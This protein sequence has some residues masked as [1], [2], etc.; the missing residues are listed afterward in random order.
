MGLREQLGAAL[1][2]EF[3]HHE[4]RGRVCAKCGADERRL[5]THVAVFLDG[6]PGVDP[7]SWVPQATSYAPARGGV[8]VCDGC[9]PPCRKCEQPV[10]AGATKK[11][12]ISLPGYGPANGYCSEHFR[13]LGLTL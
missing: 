9:A 6:N 5:A 10:L 2:E 3:K 12:L 8:A 4:S 11:W 1:K 7:R 13:I